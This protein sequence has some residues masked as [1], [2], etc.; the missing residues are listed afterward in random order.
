MANQSLQAYEQM[1]GQI[2]PNVPAPSMPAPATPPANPSFMGVMTDPT[3]T[4]RFLFDLGA[5]LA[6]PIQPGQTRA[7]HVLAAGSQELGKLT[8]AKASEASRK[9]QEAAQDIQ[10]AANKRELESADLRDDLVRSQIMKNLKPDTPSGTVAAKVQERMAKAK[11][12]FANYPQIYQNLDE[13][14]GA[15]DRM[16][17]DQT[18]EAERSQAIADYY[19]KRAIIRTP[20][21]QVADLAEINAKFDERK[22]KYLID[23]IKDPKVT[24]GVAKGAT[25][26]GPGVTDIGTQAQGPLPQTREEWTA[27]GPEGM[28][29]RLPEIRPDATPEQLQA[30]VQ[31]HFPD[32]KPPAVSQKLE[33]PPAAEEEKPKPTTRRERRASARAAA[34]KR[35]AAATTK[36]EQAA[37]DK[38]FAQAELNEML[39][40]EDRPALQVWLEKNRKNLTPA[41][42]RRVMA[43]ITKLKGK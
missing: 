9:R 22:Q 15:V 32:W 7:G 4:S 42:R 38:E 16:E 19:N 43:R 3:S 37:E 17:F 11:T 20:E 21:E 14:L 24:E 33:A 31:Q 25:G 13:A 29:A 2:R 5:R 36:E 1:L 28:L 26:A 30:V 8:Q 10:M 6:Q 18:V 41:Q 23:L 34:K 12:L 40:S 27:L 39:A 35:R